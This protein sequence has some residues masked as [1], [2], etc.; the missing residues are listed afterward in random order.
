MIVTFTMKT[1]VH[2][3]L[4]EVSTFMTF[5]TK[6][7]HLKEQIDLFYSFSDYFSFELNFWF[8]DLDVLSPGKKTVIVQ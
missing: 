7:V 4:K 3:V 5:N 1:L 2:E 6:S 8:S